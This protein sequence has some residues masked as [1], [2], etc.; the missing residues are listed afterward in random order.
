MSEPKDIDVNDGE[1]V[2]DPKDNETS[3]VTSSK[4]IEKNPTEDV[5]PDD[6]DEEVSKR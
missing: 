4:K 6:E 5:E 2:D 1:A 3:E